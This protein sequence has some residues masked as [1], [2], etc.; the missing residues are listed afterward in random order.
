MPIHDNW[1]N[2]H[3]MENISSSSTG[4]WGSKGN[5]EVFSGP[6]WQLSKKNK[7]RRIMAQ[8]RTGCG[9]LFE[10]TKRHVK[11]EGEKLCLLCEGKEKEN[12]EHFLMKCDCFEKQNIKK[13]NFMEILLGGNWEKKRAKNIFNY[14]KRISAKRERILNYFL[15]GIAATRK[16]KC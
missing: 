15:N 3:V 6:Y 9:G 10:N 5:G 11:E 8:M 12:V 4:I 13:E 2:C 14:L 16:W 7:G 1:L